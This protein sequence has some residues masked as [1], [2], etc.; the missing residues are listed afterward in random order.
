MASVLEGNDDIRNM[1]GGARTLKPA[2]ADHPSQSN[3]NHLTLVIHPSSVLRKA[4]IARAGGTGV[5]LGMIHGVAVY[6]YTEFFFRMSRNVLVQGLLS[7]Q[8]I[9]D[10][11]QKD[12]ITTVET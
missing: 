2:L 3:S 5:Y 7:Q 1:Q 10:S 6:K 8:S 11:K 4:S 12:Q 9:A